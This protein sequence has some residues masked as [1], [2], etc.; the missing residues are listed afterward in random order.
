MDHGR[1][2]LY[3]PTY[4]HVAP[5]TLVFIIVFFEHRLYVLRGKPECILPKIFK[6]WKVQLLTFELDTEPYARE[7][8]KHIEKLAK[9]CGI[10]VIQKVSHTLYDTERYDDHSIFFSTLNMFYFC[11]YSG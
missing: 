8:D 6:D 2:P 7:R 3:I 5:H 9:E 4:S 10:P 1:C 11:F